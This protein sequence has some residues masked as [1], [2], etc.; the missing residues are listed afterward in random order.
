LGYSLGQPLADQSQPTT[1]AGP[2]QIPLANTQ[3]QSVNATSNGVNGGPPLP[4]S[5][6]NSSPAGN[7]GGVNP[8][9]ATAA[10]GGGNRGN[11]LVSGFSL[12]PPSISSPPT[13]VG[14]VY[15]TPKIAM[16]DYPEFQDPDQPE[17]Q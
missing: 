2:G 12:L 8:G 10:G 14:V 17:L 5:I 16:R 6:L 7:V 1:L 13:S 9:S 3:A 4:L 15:T 11:G